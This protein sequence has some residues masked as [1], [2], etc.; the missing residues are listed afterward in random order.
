[1]SDRPQPRMIAS[2]LTLIDLLVMTTATLAG[3]PDNGRAA[4]VRFTR[5]GAWTYAIV[6]LLGERTSRL[7]V[8][9]Y[10]VTAVPIAEAFLDTYKRG[11]QVQVILAKSQRT[12]Q[13]ASAAFPA[14]RGV[15]TMIDADHATSHNKVM[16]IDTETVTMGSFTLTKAAQERNAENLLIIRDT[17]LAAQ[18]TQNWPAHAQHSQPYVGRGLR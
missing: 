12:E 10:S 17:A 7:L 1:M 15:A 4:L 14:N 18:Y 9:A 3:S 2:L 11:V 5:G 6:K 13:Y 16:V 8:Q